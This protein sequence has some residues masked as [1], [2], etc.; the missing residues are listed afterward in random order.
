MFSELIAL[1]SL[2]LRLMGTFCGHTQRDFHFTVKLCVNYGFYLFSIGGGGEVQLHFSHGTVCYSSCTSQ[3]LNICTNIEG[4]FVA[5]TDNSNHIVNRSYPDTL[6][7]LVVLTPP[8]LR[9]VHYMR[10]V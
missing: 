3:T 6:L 5:F 4:W 7:L 8:R 9:D 2:P 10:E 1:T